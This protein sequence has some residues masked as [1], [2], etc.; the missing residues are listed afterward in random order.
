MH[1]L[2]DANGRP[3]GRDRAILVNSSPKKVPAAVTNIV[4]P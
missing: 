4:T 3:L 1:R 2:K